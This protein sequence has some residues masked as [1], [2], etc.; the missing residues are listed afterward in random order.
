MMCV[1]ISC[2]QQLL[3]FLWSDAAILEFILLYDAFVLSLSL[4]FG[5]LNDGGYRSCQ[6][7]K[8]TISWIA[9]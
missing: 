1:A 6:L 8:F 2:E 3:A 9:S 5:Q 7:C 4:V